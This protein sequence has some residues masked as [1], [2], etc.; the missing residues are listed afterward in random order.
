V[1]GCL[2]LL[3]G[4]GVWLLGVVGEKGFGGVFCWGLGGWEWLLRKGEVI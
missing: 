1:A 2:R 3:V 4:L